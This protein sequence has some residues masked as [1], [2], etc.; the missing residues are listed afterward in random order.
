MATENRKM[1]LLHC[2]EDNV[3]IILDS[4]EILYAAPSPLFPD[5]TLI[6]FKLSGVE[7]RCPY[8]RETPEEI[9]S[10]ADWTVWREAT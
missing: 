6:H 8:I 5:R 2:A 4:E 1:I 10:I 3:V 9:A 7:A